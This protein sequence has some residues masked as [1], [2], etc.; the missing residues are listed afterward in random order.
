MKKVK[1]LNWLL[2][3]F[4]VFTSFN[5]A[6]CSDD[7]NWGGG[8]S[9]ELP[10]D[11]EPNL[12]GDDFYAYVNGAWHA[13]LEVSDETQGYATDIEY[14]LAKKTEA[15]AAYVPE[16]QTVLKAFYNSSIER[17]SQRLEE[18]ISE[19]VDGIETK[20]EAYLAIGACIRK[21]LMDEYVKLFMEYSEGL[22]GYTLAPKYYSQ[23]QNATGGDG[24]D[25]TEEDGEVYGEE[26][27]GDAGTEGVFSADE[28]KEKII[29]GLG[30]PENHFCD[31]GAIDNLVDEMAQSSVEELKEFIQTAVTK[32]FE[33]YCYNLETAAGVFNLELG[34]LFTYSLSRAF[35]EMY[36]SEETKEKF[37]EYGEALRETLEK[38]IQNNAWLSD[39]T[40]QQALYKLEHMRFYVGGPDEWID[41]YEADVKGEEFLDDLI[42]VKS[43][44]SRIIEA[45]IG[46][47]VYD[48][49]MLEVMYDVEGDALNSSFAV[50]SPEVNALVIYPSYL[51]EPEYSSDME[52]GKMFALFSV[53][54]HEMTHGFDIDGSKYDAFGN[55]V[56]WWTVEDRSMFEALNEA[57]SAQIG[58]FELKPGIYAPTTATIGEN[59]ADLGG[60]NLAFDALTTYLTKQGVTGEALK[61]QQRAFFEH[62]AYRFRVEYT[63]EE[64]QEQLQDEHSVN[65][66]RVNGMVQHMD[67][68]YDLYNVKEGDA[69]YLPAEKRITI[70]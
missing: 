66:V 41:G 44:R 4:V 5:H 8:N 37:L 57:F 47:G 21:G 30:L 3:L 28:V 62:Y 31:I 20:E 38:R 49:M 60:L 6:S 43:N 63:E 29:Q 24:E 45:T 64:F 34:N 25:D 39:A 58:T 36:V 10:G 14:S 11:S 65:M 16:L 15:C 70:W 67:A 50:Y 1:L 54:G 12:A 69:L 13:G 53:F 35:Y 40:K 18:V 26:Q 19:I 9:S 2:V 56:D 7:D 42:E 51:M 59:V 22:I 27:E 33:F 68:W 23:Q 32:E 48:N 46:E 61:A 55:E 52:V 17:N